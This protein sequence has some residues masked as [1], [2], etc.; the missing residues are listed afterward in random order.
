[1]GQ[2]LKFDLE[3]NSIVCGDCCN[4]EGKG[5][6]N[7]IPDNSVDLIYIDPPFFSN[8]NYEIV[9]G[10]GFEERSFG[11]R[12]KGGIEH[13]IEW[14]K[15]KIREAKRILKNT[16]SIFLHCDYHANHRLRCLLD[17][18]FGEN[19]FKNEVIWHYKRW[20]AA[21]KSLQKMHDMILWY[22]KT[23]KYKFYPI[24][25]QPTEGQLKKHEKG[26][27]RNSVMINGKRQ[28]QLIIYDEKKVDSAIR[29]GFIK[30]Q[31]FARF[32]KPKIKKT[33]EDDVWQI[34]FL[35]SQSKERIG[36]KTQKPKELLE[37]IIN[38]ASKENDLILDFFSGGGTTAEVCSDLN[39]KFIIGDVSPVAVRVTA[40][41]LSAH[42]Y[43]NYE[44]KA[45]PSTKKDYLDMN[46]H[47]FADMIC[48]L[49]GWKP[50][51]KKSG[52]SGIDGFADKGNIPIQI[53]NHKNKTGRPDIQKFLG[54]LNKYKTGFFVSWNFSPE[55]WEFKASI[56]DKKIEFIEVGKILNGLLI[57][58]DISIE[59]KKLYKER[60]KKSFKKAAKATE[61]ELQQEKQEIQKEKKKEVKKR[62]KSSNNS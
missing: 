62:R 40:D 5:W 32:I 56:K 45:L 23:K 2:K 3:K 9:W 47:K 49:M 60:V 36:Y 41:R 33:L 19:N 6:L 34:N 27:D 44:I 57:S 7:F 11:D 54:A 8:K 13:Y 43:R 4:E 24:Y 12:W 26:W 52:D 22:S 18:V 58:D 16:G 15:P 29:K 1:M 39:R 46:P 50:N 53:K 55:A 20:T 61:S 17:E 21:S 59:H 28:P 48:E 10:N 37:R 35:N 38:C 30:K 51:I 25:K 31:E 42:G 14:M